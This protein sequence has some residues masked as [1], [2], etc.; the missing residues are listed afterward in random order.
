M[1][2]PPKVDRIWLWV[3]YNKISIYP[4]F[5]LL[6]GDYN[7]SVR[8]VSPSER[9]LSHGFEMNASYFRLVGFYN[10]AASVSL[11][12]YQDAMDAQEF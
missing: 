9:R 4:I 1:Y 10:L 11:S 12:Q 2:S 5:Y 7:I 8:I 3:Y 6:K